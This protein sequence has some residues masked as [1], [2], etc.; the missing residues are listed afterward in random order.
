MAI[1]IARRQ[2]IAA[3][4]GAAAAWS[5]AASAQQPRRIGILMNADAT[6]KLHRSYLETF[7]QG[8][9]E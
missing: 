5:L 3:F 6:D 2:F 4:G 1:G 7:V 9:I 8:L